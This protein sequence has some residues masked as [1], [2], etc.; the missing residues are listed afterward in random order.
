MPDYI[1]RRQKEVPHRFL[2][3]SQTF[4]FLLLF[5]NSPS[6]HTFLCC[7][8]VGTFVEA[9]CQPAGKVSLNE[10]ALSLWQ[11]L[12]SGVN[13]SAACWADKSH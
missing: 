12:C 2:R 11:F 1:S 13:L 5:L 7:S 6:R 4:F 9:L 3:T 10:S 8:V